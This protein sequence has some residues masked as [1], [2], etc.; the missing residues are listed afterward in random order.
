MTIRRALM[1][2]LLTALAA[3]SGCDDG[4]GRRDR[5]ATVDPGLGPIT[6]VVTSVTQGGRARDLVKGTEIRVRFADATVTLTAG[7]NTMSGAYTLEESRLTV[8]MLSMTEMGCDQARMDQDTWLAGLFDKP[9]QLTTGEEP[10]IVS[11]STVLAMADRRTVAP[12]KPLVGTTW[13]LDSIGGG[14]GVL[15]S[16]PD[17]SDASLRFSE[18]EVTVSDGC[19]HGTGPV[20][21]TDG[22]IAF[23]EVLMTMLPCPS[24]RGD[25]SGALRS[26]VDGTAS[27][28]IEEN[29]LTLRNGDRFLEFRAD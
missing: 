27:Y 8:E 5:D 22:S 1:V 19:N 25:V 4:G 20:T 6:Y 18:T 10:T 29:V 11:G 15:G 3:L 7:C 21:V 23:G 12:D 9:V 28:E 2:L 24:V 14:H 17:G 16:V 13:L 26:I